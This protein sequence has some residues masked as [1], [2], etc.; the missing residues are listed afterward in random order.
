LTSVY[1]KIKELYQK[2]RENKPKMQ[3]RMK[4]ANEMLG[5]IEKGY[6]KVFEFYGLETKKKRK[7]KDA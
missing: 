2:I 1:K 7:K 6:E 5:R 3:T 4:K